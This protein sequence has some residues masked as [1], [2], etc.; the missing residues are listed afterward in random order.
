MRN[1]R[2]Y[3]KCEKVYKSGRNDKN[4]FSKL[5][6]TSAGMKKLLVQF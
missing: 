1:M 4:A 3:E 2:K 6:K 5:K